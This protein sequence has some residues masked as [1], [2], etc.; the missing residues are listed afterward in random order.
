MPVGRR[1]A[2]SCEISFILRTNVNIPEMMLFIDKATV[3]GGEVIDT[4]LT[5]VCCNNCSYDVRYLSSDIFLSE[6]P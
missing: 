1:C 5:Y 6:E 2:A 4:P 3:V